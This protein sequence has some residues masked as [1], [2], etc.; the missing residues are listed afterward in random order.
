[1]TMR[2]PPKATHSIDVGN[3]NHMYGGTYNQIGEWSRSYHATQNIGNYYKT[4]WKSPFTCL[5]VHML[6]EISQVV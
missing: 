3:F 6:M 2:D 1:M 4:K 5:K